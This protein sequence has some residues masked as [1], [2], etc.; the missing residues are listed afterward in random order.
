MACKTIWN[1]RFFTFWDLAG[2]QN[3]NL[4][5]RKI[6]IQT[7]KKRLQILPEACSG[8]RYPAFAYSIL[9]T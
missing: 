3:K 4:M 1:F 7:Q 2:F 6:F 5:Q 8:K 9:A